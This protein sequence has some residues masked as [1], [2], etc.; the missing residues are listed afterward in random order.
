MAQAPYIRRAALFAATCVIF[1][2]CAPPPPPTPEEVLATLSRIIL[3][4]ERTCEELREAFEVEHLPV[5]DYPSEAGMDFEEHTVPTDDG[6]FLRVWYLPADAN[7]GTVVI[8]PGAVGPMSC[9]LHTTLLLIQN[10]W[11]VVTYEYEGFGGS[12]GTPSLL[13]L[14]PDLET[15]VDWARA[16]TRHEQLTLLGISLGTIPSVAVAVE[17]PDAVNAVV[18]DSPVAL[19]VEIERFRDLLGV[20][21]EDVIAVL[22][23][24]LVTE[25]IID[26]MHQPLLMFLHEQDDVTP[27]ATIEMLFEL[28]A[29][30]KQLVRFPDLAHARGQYFQTEQFT[31]HLETFLT[32]VWT[33]GLRR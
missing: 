12:S 9:Y 17:R 33:G 27:P 25:V 4:P 19:G 20:H 24:T 28:A 32:E 5:V 31:L 13:T 23:P 26:Q 10:G 22:D 7:R 11:S 21:T 14:S 18:L 15:V 6:Q 8:S 29:G 16:R 3:R 2:S 30:P 1:T